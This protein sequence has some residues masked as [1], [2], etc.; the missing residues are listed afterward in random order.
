MASI[1][2]HFLAMPT[3]DMTNQ[4]VF[5]YSEL[6]YHFIILLRTVFQIPNANKSYFFCRR[7]AFFLC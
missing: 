7:K 3:P 2:P 4:S 6:K 1:L 5:F